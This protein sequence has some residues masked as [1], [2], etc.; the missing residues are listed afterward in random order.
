MSLTFT[1]LEVGSG[2]A[3]LLE[4]EQ[5]GEKWVC[6]FDSGGSKSRIKSLLKQHQIEKIDLAIC[7]HN[8]IDHANGFIGLLE[9]DFRIEE[10][11]LPGIW[12]GILQF[13]KDKKIG[14]REIYYLEDNLTKEEVEDLEKLLDGKNEDRKLDSLYD[15]EAKAI[16]YKTFDDELSYFSELIESDYFNINIIHP[17]FL[18]PYHFYLKLQSQLSNINIKLNRIIKIAGLAYQHGCKIRWFEPTNECSKNKID[19]GFMSLNSNQLIS[20][21]IIKNFLCLLQA[22]RLTEEN[23]YSLVFEY[24]LNDKDNEIPIIRFS[25][26][27]NC[28]CRSKQYDN[29]I[30]VTA[31]HHGSEANDNVYGALTQ[32]NNIIWVRSD[33][34]SSKR[35]C[36]A[37]K[38]MKNRYCL[39]CYNLNFVEEISFEYDSN[40]WNY[41]GGH[42]CDCK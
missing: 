31:P 16:D 34:K 8:D 2:D 23:E 20:V 27:S 4:K 15:N 17:A 33:R 24:C 35:P 19:F 40:K 7:S 1:S 3:F 36:V 13:I 18:P 42:K 11:W 39:A 26:D 9:S 32:G 21:R 25:A 14:W 29:N 41:I 12:T 37:F 30:I 28:I 22:I 6:L 10:I 5:N 38:N